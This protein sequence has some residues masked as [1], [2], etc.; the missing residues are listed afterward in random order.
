[1]LLEVVKVI[2]LKYEV[3]SS[4]Y[5]VTV[6]TD[7]NL[8][9]GNHENIVMHIAMGGR[10]ETLLIKISS[11]FIPVIFSWDPIHDFVRTL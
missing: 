2:S 6:Y 5:V 7:S 10:G 11:L 3:I 4:Y 9:D 1:M 8:S